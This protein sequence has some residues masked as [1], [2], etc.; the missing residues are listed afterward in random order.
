MCTAWCVDDEANLGCDHGHREN[1]ADAKPDHEAN[2][3]SGASRHYPGGTVERF[4]SSLSTS[5]ASTIIVHPATTDFTAPRVTIASNSPVLIPSRAAAS[6]S[7][8]TPIASVFDSVGSGD[9][10]IGTYVA[11]T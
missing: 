8:R 3:Q 5:L 2:Q 10:V 4:T 11:A 7:V 9:L 6:F 1:C